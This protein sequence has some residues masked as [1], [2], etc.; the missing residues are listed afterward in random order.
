MG[1]EALIFGE[2][3][4]GRK[5]RWDLVELGPLATQA[6]FYGDRAQQLTPS[7]EDADRAVARRREVGASDRE[8]R[9]GQ[10]DEARDDEGAADSEQRPP[11]TTGACA[12]GR[13]GQESAS[14]SS[15]AST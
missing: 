10:Q 1:G 2:E 14:L 7:I 5:E 15:V 9:D 13:Q 8:P 3:G 4:E 12:P 6:T 11:R